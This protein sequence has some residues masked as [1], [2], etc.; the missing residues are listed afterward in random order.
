MKCSL[1]F[2]LVPLVRS[3]CPINPW[4][5]RFACM[6]I[7]VAFVV[8]RK[9]VPKLFPFQFHTNLYCLEVT[10]CIPSNIISL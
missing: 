4:L 7:Y 2:K 3:A 6:V 10:D 1:K 5:A 8:L 9:V